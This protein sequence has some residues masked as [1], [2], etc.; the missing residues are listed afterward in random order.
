MT[1][2]RLGEPSHIF[3]ATPDEV[4]LL[5]RSGTGPSKVELAERAGQRRRLSA[6]DAPLQLGPD[7]TPPPADVLP[8]ACA[9]IQQAVAFYLEHMESVPREFAGG[10]GRQLTGI[11]A[12][13]GRYEGR[14]RVTTGPEDFERLRRGD[15]L[16]APTTSPAY[17][18]ILPLLGAVVT[19]TGGS[20]CHAAIVAREFAIP[21]VVGT[22]VAT[23]HIPDGARIIVDGD[24]GLVE[25]LP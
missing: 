20:L 10:R 25:V 3:D 2:D 9:R 17:N 15:V 18:V 8:P 12:S 21:A 23:S 16:V 13:G 6:M 14:A 4:R 24:R 22:G 5:L 7:E 1:R 19:D 11:A